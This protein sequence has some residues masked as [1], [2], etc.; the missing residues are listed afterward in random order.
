[1]SDEITEVPAGLRTVAD[2][3]LTIG[4]VAGETLHTEISAKF[5]P[6]GIAAELRA[7]GM[8][9]LEF[10]TDPAG[11]FGLTLAQLAR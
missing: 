3:D 11:E 4:F 6:D 10:W 5:R 9:T 8:Q 2:L 1:M 7:A